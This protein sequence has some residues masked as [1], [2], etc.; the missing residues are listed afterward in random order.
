MLG[1]YLG[2]SIRLKTLS[3]KVYQRLGLPSPT[4]TTATTDQLIS[5]HS[6]E[7]QAQIGSAE[8]RQRQIGIKSMNKMFTDLA[9]GRVD[10]LVIDYLEAGGYMTALPPVHQLCLEV[11]SR[12]YPALRSFLESIYFMDLDLLRDTHQYLPDTTSQIIK[13]TSQAFTGNYAPAIDQSGLVGDEYRLGNG[14]VVEVYS[15]EPLPEDFWPLFLAEQHDRLDQARQTIANCHGQQAPRDLYRLGPTVQVLVR[16]ENEHDRKAYH[17]LDSVLGQEVITI[18]ELAEQ[19]SIEQS[20]NDLATKRHRFLSQRG[21]IWRGE[22]PHGEPLAITVQRH[23]R[24][25]KAYVCTISITGPD[26]Q[27]RQGRVLMDEQLRF[28]LG[29]RRAHARKTLLAYNAIAARVLAHFRRSDTV[30]TE[31]GSLTGEDL[32]RTI[33][34]AHLHFLQPGQNFSARRWQACWEEQGEDLHVLSRN[35]AYQTGQDRASTYISALTS[36]DPLQGPLHIYLD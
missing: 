32:G 16:V 9:R 26:G 36:N 29:E 2:D 28:H 22:T 12:R 23:P 19:A 4:T 1:S 14:L 24:S 10:P 8:L 15:S 18:D 7:A 17:P 3:S 31:E 21:I 33:R 5:L 34:V 30:R 27:P 6:R 35:R 13:Y 25:A 11:V 20:R